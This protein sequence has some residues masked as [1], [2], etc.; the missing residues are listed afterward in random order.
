M[1]RKD[2]EAQE[3]AWRRYHE[4]EATQPPESST[5]AER[6]RA[7]ADLVELYLSGHPDDPPPVTLGLKERIAHLAD[8]QA[9]L[10]RTRYPR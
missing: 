4:W 9:K 10:R 1:D 6:F 7:Y 3:S 2:W 8:I 5:P